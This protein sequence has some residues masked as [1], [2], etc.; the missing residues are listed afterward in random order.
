MQKF[1]E[2]G[3]FSSHPTNTKAVKAVLKQVTKSQTHHAEELHEQLP[4]AQKLVH[5]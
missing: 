4:R 3:Y 1:L 5:K 2:A